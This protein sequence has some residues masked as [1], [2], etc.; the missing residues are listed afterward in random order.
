MIQVY[1]AGNTNFEMN[2]DMTLFPTSCEVDMILKGN[3]DME[4]VH[5]IDDGG[6]WKYVVE[7]NVICAPTPMGEKQ[8]FRIY[9]KKKTQTE[10][11][12]YARPIFFDSAKDLFIVDTRPTQK[13]G[14]DALNEMLK[15]SKYS[16]T[17]NILTVNTAY[18]INKNFMA[19]LQGD[20][21]NA[22]LN[23]W[24]GEPL[25]DNYHVIVNYRAGG[26]YGVSARFGCNLKS[27]EE[28]IDM[29]DVVTRIVPMSYNGHM[30][31]G[32]TPWVDSPNISKYPVI[33]TKL[34]QFED[35]KLTED[36]NEDETGWGTIQGLRTELI[37]RCNKM[38]SEGCDLPK[39]NYVI[40]MLDLSQTEEYKNYKILETVMLGDTIH[41]THQ[42]LNI[43][44]KARAIR[45][46]YDCIKKRNIEEELGDATFDYFSNVTTD[47]DNAY[48]KAQ[49]ANDNAS[50]AS[51]SA[52][53][54]LDVANH[55]YDAS[56]LNYQ[57]LSKILNS[58]GTVRGDVVKGALNAF[59]TQLTY[60]KNISQKQDVRAILFEDTDINSTTYGALAIGTLGLQIADKRTSDGRD[61]DWTTAITAKGG[62]ADIFVVG[63]MLANRIKGGTLTLGGNSNVNG[64]LKVLNNASK[65][66]LTLDYKGLLLCTRWMFSD[67]S[68]GLYVDMRPDIFNGMAIHPNEDLCGNIAFFSNKY[69]GIMKDNDNP[70][71]V[72][73]AP[74]METYTSFMANNCVQ[75]IGAD[76][77][78]DYSSM[79]ADGFFTTGDSG[80][81]SS[82]ANY[83]TRALSAYEMASPMSGDIGSG[84]TDENGECIVELDDIFL[85]TVTT[86]IEYQVFLQKEGQG[87]LWVDSKE[88]TCFV[89]KGTPNLKFSW[90]LKTVRYDAGYTRLEEYPEVYSVDDIIDEEVAEMEG[91]Y[92]IEV[93]RIMQEEE[94][95]LL[96]EQS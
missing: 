27:I 54:A 88:P 90:E 56:E 71:N 13:D 76:W 67:S 82:T 21:D 80:T 16:G 44:T 36:C 92:E 70:Y 49:Q 17:S 45:I 59:N 3:W 85:E 46:K 84:I 55:A 69:I 96:Y 34:V 89:V 78:N 62:V 95:Q 28:T 31:D 63:T 74:N 58:D 6:R 11:T 65:D 19:A 66:I 94:E 2:G 83:S 24:G 81:V 53:Q 77:L 22:F 29:D 40:D 23:R 37:R 91:L 87:D 26:D 12:A 10:V 4:L 15:G 79:R 48:N 18:Y 30:L 33:Y 41:C 42:R 72:P 1:N 61:W 52:Q 86:D 57:N 35:V 64:S 47:L 20:D 43:E 38:F 51:Q 75:V 9:N 60:Q 8:L 93:D 5:P 32:D 7:G 25:Y 39:C 14:Q 68:K 73:S 50:A